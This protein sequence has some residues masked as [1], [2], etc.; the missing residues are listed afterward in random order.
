MNRWHLQT[1]YRNIEKEHDIKFPSTT[2]G[3]I[4]IIIKIMPSNNVIVKKKI[5]DIRV[6]KMSYKIC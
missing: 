1:H 2:I 3:K 5:L 6:E 4:S